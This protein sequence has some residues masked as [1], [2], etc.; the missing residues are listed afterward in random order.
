MTT[1]AEFLHAILADPDSTEPRLVYADWLDER[2]DPRGEFIRLQM[3]LALADHPA[4]HARAHQ[5]RRQHGADWLGE[6]LATLVRAEKADA[7]YRR[8]FIEVVVTRTDVFLANAA[9]LAA[10]HPLREV[11]LMDWHV[12]YEDRGRFQS[13]WRVSH[14]R[15]TPLDGIPAVRGW[16]ADNAAAAN[17]LARAAARFARFLAGRLVECDPCRGRVG[18]AEGFGPDYDC[19]DCGG[20]GYVRRPDANLRRG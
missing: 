20:T 12:E 4:L 10:A 2:G 7:I 15:S 19:P 5:L 1:D 11:R 14:Y 13:C 17:A 18:Q 6:P 9:A 8:G 16:H 3:E